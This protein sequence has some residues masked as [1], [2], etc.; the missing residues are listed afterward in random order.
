MCAHVHGM[1]NETAT[2]NTLLDEAFQY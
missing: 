1:R 2:G